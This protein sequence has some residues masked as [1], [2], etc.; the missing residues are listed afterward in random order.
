MEIVIVSFNVQLVLKWSY[1]K[2]E[3][4]CF[5]EHTDVEEI[6]NYRIHRKPPAGK[7]LKPR[8]S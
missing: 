2:A 4:S 8:R 7:P 3:T 1:K 5:N 6:Q